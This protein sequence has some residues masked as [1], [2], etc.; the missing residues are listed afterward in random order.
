MK[1][2][3]IEVGHDYAYR[4]GRQGAFTRVKCL[5]IQRTSPPPRVVVR[6][7]DDGLKDRVTPGR[8][9]VEWDDRDALMERESRLAAVCKASLGYNDPR[10]GACHVVFDE[11][12]D[13]T[14]ASAGHSRWAGVVTIFDVDALARLLEIEPTELESDSLAFRD[15]DDLVAPWGD[16][17]A[18]R[19]DFVRVE[20]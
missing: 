19:D 14:V 13:G 11:L 2:D 3:E 17:P 9:H 6:F 7:E 1:I 10:E 8:L 12:I 4:V 16:D 18:R 5:E 15:G 20:F